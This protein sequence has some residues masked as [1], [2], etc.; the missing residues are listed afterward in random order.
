MNDHRLL[1][2]VAGVAFLVTF[3]VMSPCVRNDFTRWDDDV[4]LNELVKHPRLSWQTLRWAFTA[5]QPFYYQP[6]TW[7]THVL[8]FQCWGLR[9]GGHHFVS[10]LLHSCNAAIVVCLA[11]LLTGNLPVAFAIGVVFGINTLQVE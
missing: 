8:D 1:W 11:W 4:Y 10:V 7:L 3:V 6:L 5:T 9:A 2:F